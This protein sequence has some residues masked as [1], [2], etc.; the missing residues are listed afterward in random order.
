MDL[1]TGYDFNLE[2]DRKR[3]WEKIKKDK[4]KLL[5]GSPECRMFSA[6][7][8]LSPWNKKKQ[9]GYEEAKKHLKFTCELYKHQISEGRWFLH[10]HWPAH[11]KRSATRES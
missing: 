11:G 2:V 10:E 8:I 9:K 5:V 7:Q 4:P 1:M 6:L 3:A